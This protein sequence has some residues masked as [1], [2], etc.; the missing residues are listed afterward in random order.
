[1]KRSKAGNYE[2][3][4]C[5]NQTVSVK[6]RPE[7]KPG[8]N[9]HHPEM[10]SRNAKQKSE[11]W[12]S[13]GAALKGHPGLLFGGWEAERWCGHQL[14]DLAARNL[15]LRHCALEQ[16]PGR[17]HQKTGVGKISLP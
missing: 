14:V 2:Q 9:L 8:G 10:Q 3:V 1:M 7:L 13:G 4:S 15:G 5:Q 17:S 12:G 16:G 11:R 6:I